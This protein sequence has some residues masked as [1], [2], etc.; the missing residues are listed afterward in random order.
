MDVAFLA[1]RFGLSHGFDQAPKTGQ[2]QR[3]ATLDRHIIDEG[4]A[5]D[6][7]HDCEHTAPHQMAGGEGNSARLCEALMD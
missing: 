4:S 2:I 7:E 1:F 6:K 5:A 3:S